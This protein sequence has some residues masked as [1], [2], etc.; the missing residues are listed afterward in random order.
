MSYDK[1]KYLKIL[2]L[3]LSHLIDDVAGLIS[4]EKELHERDEHTNFVYLENLVVLKDEIMGINGIIGK[5]D[6]IALQLDDNMYIDDLCVSLEKFIESR[7][8]P[9]AVLD[10]IKGK[11]KKIEEINEIY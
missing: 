8:Y 3:E 2:K 9:M 6:E 1:D 7:G 11:I 5:I 10:L 4:Y